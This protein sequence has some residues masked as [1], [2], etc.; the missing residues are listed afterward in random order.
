M[1][2]RVS[3]ADRMHAGPPCITFMYCVVLPDMT[4]LC[5]MYWFVEQV[6]FSQCKYTSHLS[7]DGGKYNLEQIH[8]HSPS[9]HMV[10][11]L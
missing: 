10:R 3:A 11:Y 8:L 6:D 4:V 2:S 5:R 9:E 7:F 1:D